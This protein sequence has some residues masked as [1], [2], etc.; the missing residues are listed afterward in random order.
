MSCPLQPPQRPS[1]LA[2]TVPLRSSPSLRL[3]PV[4]VTPL[5]VGPLPAQFVR[6]IVSA[7]SQMLGGMGVENFDSWGDE[8][9]G[10]GGGG[11][12][13]G[14]GGSSKDAG[15]SGTPAGACAYGSGA[16]GKDVAALQQQKKAAWSLLRQRLQSRPGARGGSVGAAAATSAPAAEAAGSDPGAPAAGDASAAAAE[17]IEEAAQLANAPIP[18]S[19]PQTT[20]PRA[21]DS[22][23]SSAAG[24]PYGTPFDIL[25]SLLV[26]QRHAA[27]LSA[28]AGGAAGDRAAA[29][30]AAAASGGTAGEPPCLPSAGAIK[31]EGSAVLV[32]AAGQGEGG[33]DHQATL[34][35]F[36]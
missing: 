32:G 35:Q 2:S 15:A 10:G 29:G 31:R 5:T 26:H 33:D 24:T 11:N 27:S 12:G 19:S 20:P 21:T 1:L 22:C 18:C 25:P 4:Q 34:F 9:A 3:L 16:D 17:A 13:A 30:A 23:G 8:P 6:D 14:G 7:R 36:E 28:D